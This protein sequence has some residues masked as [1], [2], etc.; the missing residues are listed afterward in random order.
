MA[1]AAKPDAGDAVEP[2]SAGRPRSSAS[3]RAV[4][5]AAY[6]LLIEDGLGGFTVEAVATRSGVARTTIYRWW[7]SK[8]LLA[9]ES[10]LEAFGAQL[11]F[12]NTAAPERDVRA[13]IASLARALSGPAG[14]LAASVMAQAQEDPQVQTQFLEQFS[15]PLR[16]HSAGVIGA[17]VRAGVFRAD[18]DV[19]R[20]LDAAVGAVY[21]RLMFGLPLDPAW[22]DA[23]STT[24][25]SGCLPR[26]A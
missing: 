4:L 17:G 15:L 24:L 13:L 5:E 10:F 9:F 14:R 11:E 3:R 23:L 7:A 19:E 20:L 2:R 22:A 8:G 6:A 18:L 25:I 21:L 1:A 26:P 12:E 16:R